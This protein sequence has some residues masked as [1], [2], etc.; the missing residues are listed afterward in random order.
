MTLAE[1]LSSPLPDTATL[2]TLAIVF[3]TP[4]AQRMVN[5]HAWYGDPRC[6]VYQAATADGRWFHVADIL[7]EC[8]REGGMYAAGFARLN[9]ANFVNVEVM[10]LADLEIAEEPP[11]ALEPEEGPPPEPE[12][13]PV[14]P[15]A[16]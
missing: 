16:E 11:A 9:A 2:Q 1:F 6:T 5:V 8:I 15:P 14:D 13:E 4:L 12:P 7:P 3:D 10:P